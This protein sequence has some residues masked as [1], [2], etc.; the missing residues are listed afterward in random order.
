MASLSAPP[1]TLKLN[2]QAFWILGP[3]A[4]RVPQFST[5]FWFRVSATH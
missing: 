2:F 4:S 1:E 3:K 5:N